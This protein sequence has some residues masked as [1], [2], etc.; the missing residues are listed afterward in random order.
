MEADQQLFRELLE[1]R[2]ML[3]GWFKTPPVE[4]EYPVDALLISRVI[5]NE[6]LREAATKARISRLSRE[7]WKLRRRKTAR[8]A[9]SRL[10]LAS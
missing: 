3:L 10:P 4:S 2:E 9:V 7:A 8:P 5:R 6:Q 1:E